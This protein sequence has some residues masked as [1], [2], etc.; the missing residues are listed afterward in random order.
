MALLRG[1]R[2]VKL[3]DRLDLKFGFGRDTAGRVVVGIHGD[4]VRPV[5]SVQSFELRDARWIVI[6]RGGIVRR[7]DE[8]VAARRGLRILVGDAKAQCL[9]VPAAEERETEAQQRAKMTFPNDDQV[10]NPKQGIEATDFSFPFLPATNCFWY[11]GLSGSF[12]LVIA[13]RGFCKNQ[14]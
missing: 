13:G 14:T 3:R 5:L 2:R 11:G 6:Q 8:G 12:C 1:V 4:D 10:Y 7:R 9:R